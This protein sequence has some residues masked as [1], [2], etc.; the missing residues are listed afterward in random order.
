MHKKKLMVNHLIEALPY[1][2]QFRNKVF[3]FKYGGSIIENEE[4]KKAFIEDVSL[5]QHLGMKVIIVHGGGKHI[6]RRLEEKGIETIFHEGY[7]IT[8]S[9]AIDE[10][11]MILSGH[12]NKELT[13]LFNNY[14]TKAIGVNG[15]DAGLIVAKKKIVSGNIDIGHVGDVESINAEFLEL[16]LKNDYLPIISPIGFDKSG[17]T[18]NINADDVA[19]EIAKSMKAEKLFL[20]SDINGV[21]TILGEESTFISRLDYSQASKM[22]SDGII[23]GG[24]IPKMKSCLESIENGVA[25]VHIING[26]ITHS[27]LLEVFTDEGIGTMIE[28]SEKHVDYE[29]L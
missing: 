6:S 14:G 8:N 3:V 2:M 20:I 11:E 26:K 12:I 22:I 15:K 29:D 24:M 27:V 1:I 19:S 4:N 13:L 7:R 5:L 17:N 16:L 23:N 10:V 21:Y 18:Y 25:S 9:Q 28:R